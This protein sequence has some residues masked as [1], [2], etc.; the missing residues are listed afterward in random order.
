MNVLDIALT[1]SPS[2][3]NQVLA[4]GLAIKS[5]QNDLL[6]HDYLMDE[7]N[8]SEDLRIRGYRDRKRARTAKKLSKRTVYTDAGC[9]GSLPLGAIALDIPAYLS[10][11]NYLYYT[12]Y[13]IIATTSQYTKPSSTAKPTRTIR[14]Q[15]TT[16]VYP[17]STLTCRGDKL[18][19]ACYHYSSAAQKSTYSWA[20]CSNVAFSADYRRLPIRWNSQHKSYEEWTAYIAKSYVNG[21]NKRKKV[22]CDRDEWPPNHFQQGRADGLIRFLPQ[23]QNRA[24]GVTS[25]GGWKGF[26][27][28]PPERTVNVQGGPIVDV[29]PSYEQTIFTSTIITLSVMRY[30]WASVSP[31]GGDPFGLTANVCRPSVLTND[32]GFALFT[33]DAWYNGNGPSAYQFSPGALTVGKSQPTW[34]KRDF[35]WNEQER[36]MVVDEGNTTRRATPEELE[37]EL[38]LTRC[39]T[40]DCVAELEIL[41]HQQAEEGFATVANDA[42]KTIEA[43]LTPTPASSTSSIIITSTHAS[44]PGLQ[45]GISQPTATS[46]KGTAYGDWTHTDHHPHHHHHHHHHR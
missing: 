12:D 19:Q 35:I 40:P 28:F 45:P 18:P 30:T 44:R 46:H 43:V 14:T 13:K 41:A 2:T 20:T 27:K 31:P 42:V 39:A 5:N 22:S 25:L 37:S 21:M 4:G 7:S 17:T 11:Q 38:G 36:M 23:D 3:S 1:C 6:D 26:C 32:V 24:A 8:S 34:R 15:V 10:V 33:D 29:G 16:T 9:L